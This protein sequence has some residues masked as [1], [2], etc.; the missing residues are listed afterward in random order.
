CI[1][2]FRFTCAQLEEILDVLQVPPRIKSH[3]RDNVDS[4]TVLCMTIYRLSYPARLNR[5]ETVFRRS[6][7]AMSRLIN[8]LIR[9]IMLHWNQLLIWDHHRLTPAKLQEYAKL[10]CEK[11]N[12]ECNAVFGF[13]DGTVRRINRPTA[14]QASMYNG[15][16][17]VHAL[18]YQSIV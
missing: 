3:N 8:H 1:Q 11:S 9:W 18:K 12:H 17:H 2:E 14:N 13:I 5:M 4:L 16:K 7:S 6:T 10:C 15:H